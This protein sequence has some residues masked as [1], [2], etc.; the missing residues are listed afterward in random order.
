MEQLLNLI[1]EIA[2]ND[3]MKKVT[4][5]KPYISERLRKEIRERDEKYCEHCGQTKDDCPGYKCWI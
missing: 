4:N 2:S 3:E 5:I 1:N